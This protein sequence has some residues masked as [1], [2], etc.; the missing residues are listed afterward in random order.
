MRL[1]SLLAAVA[2]FAAPA[3]SQAGFLRDVGTYAEDRFNDVLDL[4]RLRV[5]APEQAKGWG[6]KARVTSAAQIGYVFFNGTYAGIDR[7][8]VGIVDERRREMGVSFLYGSWNQMNPRWGNEFLRADTDW[9]RMADR[10]IIR[11]LPHWDDGRQRPLSVGAEVATPI[12]ALDA[13]VYPEEALDLVLGILTIDIFHD[14][15]LRGTTPAYDEPSAEPGPNADAPFAARRAKFD[16]EKAR[17]AKEV[18][19]EKGQLDT[20]A[21][22]PAEKAKTARALKVETIT[23]EAADAAV[24]KLEAVEAEAPVAESATPDVDA[25]EEAPKTEE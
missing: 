20:P 18:L 9:T 21:A 3:A 12:L 17:W 16:E 8:G 1:R 25:P 14:D 2:I 13:G 4:V 23:P 6:A 7:R 19:E 24:R 22:K 5:G 10:R 15:K 11:N